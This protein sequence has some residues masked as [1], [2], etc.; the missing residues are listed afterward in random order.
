[1]TTVRTNDIDAVVSVII[2]RSSSISGAYDFNK[3]MTL[4]YGEKKRDILF[5][6]LVWGV[7]TV[8]SVIILFLGGYG[9]VGVWCWI[10]DERP[11]VRMWLWYLPLW[12]VWVFSIVLAVMTCFFTGRIKREQK[13]MNI[14]GA[15]SS[16]NRQI[17]FVIVTGVYFIISFFF[18]WFAPTFNRAHQAFSVDGKTSPH[19]VW[20]WHLLTGARAD[21]YT[22]F[23][24][25][26]WMV[27]LS[28]KREK[29]SDISLTETTGEIDRRYQRAY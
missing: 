5:H 24:L 29:R 22:K 4:E 28:R 14:S 8:D 3:L 1:M 13:K 10:L 20:V 11:M 6:S 19:W 9:D 15:S 12:G 7:A 16:M 27:F 18:A 26:L 25:F 23:L 2:P 21:G 17:R